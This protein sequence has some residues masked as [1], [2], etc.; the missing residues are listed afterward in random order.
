MLLTF[1][2]LGIG[3]AGFSGVVV[4]FGYRG[5]L[6]EADRFRFLSAFT[7]AVCVVVL[8]VLPPALAFVI[9]DAQTIWRLSSAVA[10]G[11]FVVATPLFVRYSSHVREELEKL[12]VGPDTRWVTLAGIL[13]ALVALQN[14]IGWPLAPSF[15]AHFVCMMLAFLVSAY[16]FAAIVVHRPKG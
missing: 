8:A 6:S 12:A 2:E 15:A 3:L 1:A 14:V 16:T 4:A 11:Y 7:I 10:F 9:D 5:A 13:F